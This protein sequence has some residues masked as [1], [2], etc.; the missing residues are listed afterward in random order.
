MDVL[1]T[2]NL[3]LASEY[4]YNK[5]D[6]EYRCVVFREDEKADRWKNRSV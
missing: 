1:F 2:G 6:K 4:F 3:K 5:F